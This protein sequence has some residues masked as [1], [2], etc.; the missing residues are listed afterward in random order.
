M[1]KTL[2]L[3]V[4]IAVIA[5]SCST[6]DAPEAASNSGTFVDARDG[7]EYKFVKIGVQTWMAENLNYPETGSKCY[8]DAASC[9]EYGRLYDWETAKRAC[10]PGWHLPS[11][12]EW[13]ILVDFAGGKE[14]ETAGKKL[15][16]KSGWDYNY[17]NLTSGDG[18]DT[19]GFSA[20]PGGSNDFNG[21]FG[22]AGSSGYWWSATPYDGGNAYFRGMG[23][24]RESVGYGNVNKRYLLS[25]RCLQD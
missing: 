24:D 6:E 14:I 8:D 2:P 4:A 18:I 16:A 9:T 12:T 13:G 7:K 11:D 20:L 25:V 1:K 21:Y 10:P 22:E 17:S 5:F 3:F 15:K 19:Y 23:Y